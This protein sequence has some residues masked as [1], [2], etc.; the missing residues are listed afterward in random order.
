MEPGEFFLPVDHRFGVPV[1]SP[2]FILFSRKFFSPVDDP[3]DQPNASMDI[4]LNAE[5]K[6]FRMLM[7]MGWKESTGL[8]KDGSGIVDPIRI[9]TDDVQL[10]LGKAEEI[11]SRFFFG[12]RLFF[13]LSFALIFRMP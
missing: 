1:V 10:G 11:V 13:L 3:Y 9:K 7:K 8:G 12:K 2:L 4:A 6:G 5:N